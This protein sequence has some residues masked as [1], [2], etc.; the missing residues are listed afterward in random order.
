MKAVY[1]MYKNLFCKNIKRLIT[2]VYIKKPWT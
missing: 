2:N 1:Y